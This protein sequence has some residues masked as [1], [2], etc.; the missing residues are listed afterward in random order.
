MASIQRCTLGTYLRAQDKTVSH[1]FK[2]FTKKG[3]GGQD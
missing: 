3:T 1:L 2:H